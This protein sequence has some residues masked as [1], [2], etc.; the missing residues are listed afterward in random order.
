[1]LW[2]GMIADLIV[3]VHAAYVGFVVLGLVAILAGHCLSLE[4]GPKS[5][6]P[7]DTHRDDWNRGCGGSRRDSVPSYG[8]GTAAQSGG[9]ASCLSGRL[10]RILDPPAAFL[11]CGA[12]GI[13]GALR[14]IRSG[15]PGCVCLRA[16]SMETGCAASSDRLAKIGV[17]RLRYRDLRFGALP[18]INQERRSW[19]GHVR[20]V[21]EWRWLV[22]SSERDWRTGFA[23]GAFRNVSVAI[24]EAARAPGEGPLPFLRRC[25]R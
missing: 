3:V 20:R 15:R 22:R 2:R 13:H 11:S 10:H 16:A 7:L 1:M 18:P 17:N 6:V 25:R 8:M 9:R 19:L 24:R 12:V 4:M 14:G 5:L 21:L 23:R